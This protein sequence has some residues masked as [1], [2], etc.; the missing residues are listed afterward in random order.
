MP[1]EQPYRLAVLYSEPAPYTLACLRRL[2]E[3]HGVEILAV[4]WQ[5]AAVAPFVF[6]T[7]GFLARQHARHELDEAGIARLLDEFAPDC[8]YVS[9]WM[10]KGYVRVARRFRQRGVTVV[11]GLDG[12]WYGT[13]RQYVATWLGRH[14]LQGCFD[15]IWVTGERQAQYARRLGF[16]GARLRYGFYCCDWERFAALYDPA[17][18]TPAGA[19]LYLGRYAPEKGLPDLLAAYRAYREQSAA[20]WELHCVGAGPL[21]GLLAGQPGVRDLGFLQAEEL[22]GVLRNAS[23]LVLPSTYEP[24]GVAIQEAAVAGKVLVCSDACGAAVHLLQDRYNGY[25]FAAGD[26]PALAGCL[27]AVERLPVDERAAMGRASHEL[28]RQY[29]PDRWAETLYR[30]ISDGVRP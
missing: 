8:I 12:Q 2:H 18:P 21:K 7:T 13:P 4:F 19:F 23:A 28:S 9:G 25:L 20:P 29:T 15:I 24:W 6:D 16:Q 3:A 11:A 10:D 30:I 17:E 14:Y 26:V 22:P 27:E 1:T 5:A